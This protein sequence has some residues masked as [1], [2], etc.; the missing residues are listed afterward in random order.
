M[1]RT[2]RRRERLPDERVALH[3]IGDPRRQAGD[4][5]ID[6]QEGGRDDR[7][8]RS[9]AEGRTGTRHDAPTAGERRCGE[10]HGADE[11][12]ER[13]ERLEGV[14]RIPPERRGDRRGDFVRDDRGDLLV[15]LRPEALPQP[16]PR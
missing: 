1:R 5:G 2:P 13:E 9:D 16:A 8:G 15:H 10:R 3:C 12:Q 14:A 7:R 6:A 4:A 11:E